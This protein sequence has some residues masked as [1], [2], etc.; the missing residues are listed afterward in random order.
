MV[1][2]PIPVF[3]PVTMTTLPDRSG[4]WSVENVDLGGK[5]WL[6]KL[7]KVDSCAPM[8]LCCD[9]RVGDGGYLQDILIGLYTL[10]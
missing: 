8:L 4:I 9:S 10:P 6:A 1:S 7:E 5:V 2:L 3:P